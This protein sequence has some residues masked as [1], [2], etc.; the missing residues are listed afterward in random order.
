[1]LEVVHLIP[2]PPSLHPSVRLFN[3]PA[4]GWSTGQQ[5]TL[6]HAVDWSVGF[7]S[8]GR[9]AL[10]FLFPSARTQTH[11]REIITLEK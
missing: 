6:R 8:S 10:A 11:K 7:T 9:S 1:M 5:L 2:H 4:T 3:P